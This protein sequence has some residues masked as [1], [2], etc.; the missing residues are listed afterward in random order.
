MRDFPTNKIVS[1]GKCSRF[2]IHFPT[3]IVGV[4]CNKYTDAPLKSA[5]WTPL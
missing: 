2:D 5:S 1:V 3:D 4:A